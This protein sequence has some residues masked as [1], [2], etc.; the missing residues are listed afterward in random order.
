MHPLFPLLDLH[1]FSHEYFCVQWS[2]LREDMTEFMEKRDAAAAVSPSSLDLHH[3]QHHHRHRHR[4]RH[5]HLCFPFYPRP[6][7]LPAIPLLHRFHWKARKVTPASKES[8]WTQ[9]G[10]LFSRHCLQMHLR[11]G[12][13]LTADSVKVPAGKVLVTMSVSSA[14]YAHVVDYMRDHSGLYQLSITQEKKK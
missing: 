5:R 12:S 13:T 11:G 14:T 2:A 1:G 10:T 8:D 9:P 4:H 6:S 3:S 7:L